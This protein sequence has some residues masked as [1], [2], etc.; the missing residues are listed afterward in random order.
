MSKLK[1][2]QLAFVNEYMVDRNA[3][4]AAIRAGY[5]EKTAHSIGHE[6]LRKPEIAEEIKRREQELAEANK[7]T[8]DEVVRLAANVARFDVRKLVGPDGM[9]KPIT[10]LDDETA[11]AIQG[12][13]IATMGNA[14]AGL[15]EVTKYKVADRNQA[16]DK[17]MKHLGGYERDNEQKQ[18]GLA[19]ALLAGIERA[20]S[21]E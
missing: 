20:K 8:L 4:Q 12:V 9:P 5:S 10:E 2:K 16:I 13:E 17:L 15:G 6:N 1:G 7:I 18:A 21:V 3:T 19:E 14:D 11:L